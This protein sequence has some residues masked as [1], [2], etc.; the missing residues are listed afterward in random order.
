M[1]KYII[2][3]DDQYFRAL[4]ED[5]ESPENYDTEDML[6]YHIQYNNPAAATL[7]IDGQPYSGWIEAEEKM[8]SPTDINEIIAHVKSLYPDSN[9]E[10]LSKN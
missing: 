10:L 3:V 6:E 4:P 9:V 8:K 5:I 2:K 7:F 1:K